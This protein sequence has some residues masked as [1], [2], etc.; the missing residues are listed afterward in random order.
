MALPFG[1]PPFCIYAGGS[2]RSEITR[3]GGKATQSTTSNSTSKLLSNERAKAIASLRRASAMRM[4]SVQCG[5]QAS[6]R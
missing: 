4:P 1:A 2:F 5:V 3:T 6:G